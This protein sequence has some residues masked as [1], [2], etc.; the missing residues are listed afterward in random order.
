MKCLSIIQASSS[1]KHLDVYTVW[2][3]QTKKQTVKL[4][5]HQTV[6]RKNG[7]K[8]GC[9]MFLLLMGLKRDQAIIPADEISEHCLY[10]QNY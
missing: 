10:S 8:N 6:N 2:H 4:K 9:L 7:I 5:S 1:F 3:S